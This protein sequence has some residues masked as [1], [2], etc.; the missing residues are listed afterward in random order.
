MEPSCRVNRRGIAWIFAWLCLGW[1]GGTSLEAGSLYVYTDAQGQPVLTDNLQQVPPEYRGRVR[2]MGGQEAVTPDVTAPGTETTVR[3][4]PASSGVTDAIL[5]TLAQRVSKHPIKGLT[6]YQTA[7]V[8]A[9]GGCWVVLL[10]LLCLSANPAV[11]LLSKFLMLLVG[12]SAVYRLSIGDIM[13]TGVADSPQQASEQTTDNVME[14]MKS[15][16]EHSYRLQDERTTRQ[17]SQDE[18]TA[19]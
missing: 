11:R 18:Q 15:K 6:P 13:P 8:I 9:A 19:P 10:S 14:R 3:K 16:T 4:E 17:L 12:V 1:Q 7:V 5:G 2:T